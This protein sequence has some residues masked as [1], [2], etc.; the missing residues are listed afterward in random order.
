[1]LGR[2]TSFPLKYSS[3]LVQQ[4]Y[5]L[6]SVELSPCRFYK[7]NL[8]DVLEEHESLYSVIYTILLTKSKGFSRSQECRKSIRRQGDVAG[9]VPVCNSIFGDQEHAERSRTQLYFLCSLVRIKN[10]NINISAGM[11]ILKFFLSIYCLRFIW[12]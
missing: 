7:F 2:T 1:M 11:D 8:L 3:K 4:D 12:Y 6:Q 10:P 5:G 9:I